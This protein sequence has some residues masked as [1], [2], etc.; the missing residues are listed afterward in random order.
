MQILLKNITLFL[1]DA[2]TK[3]ISNCYEIDEYVH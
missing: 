1:I 2:D 3:K